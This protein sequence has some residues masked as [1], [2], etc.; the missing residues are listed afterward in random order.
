MRK[1]HFTLVE[2]LTVVAIIGILAGMSLGI[3]SYVRGKNR[4]VQTQTT[5]KL[6]EMILGQ[7]KQK[8]GSYPVFSTPGNAITDPFFKLP[9]T[10]GDDKLTALFE[11]VQFD[12]DKIKG[13]K[14]V[15]IAVD[16]D[17]MIVWIL[18]GWGFPIVY[19]Y[20]GVFNRG[21]YDLGSAG[22]DK[23]LGEDSGS[24]FTRETIPACGN[25]TGGA[26]KTH[27]GKADDI[28]NFKRT[29]N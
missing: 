27:F 12:G 21:K 10:P 18:D 28:T 4:E 16:P 19:L 8:Y 20:P 24:K 5:I 2:V 11:D 15:N 14:G 3:A 7:Y 23:L 29:D 22:P 17:S 26:Y 13:I 1:K 9:Q 25:R 6:L